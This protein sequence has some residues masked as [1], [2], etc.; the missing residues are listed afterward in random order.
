MQRVKRLFGSGLS[1][2]LSISGLMATTSMVEAA[3]S[4]IAIAIHGGA[5]TL[6][7]KSMTKKDRLA[8]QDALASAVRAGYAVLEGGGSSLDAVT[9][10]VQ[11]LEDSPRFN[12][13]VGAV[14]NWDGEHELDASIMRG[15]TM[16]AGAVAGVR[17]IKSPIALARLVM[18]RSPHVMLSGTGAEEFADAF[19][20]ERVSNDYFTTPNRKSAWRFW[21][22]QQ[23]A[24]VSRS[25]EERSGTV[26]AV[27]IDRSG[28]LAAATSTGGMTGKRWGRIGDSPVIGAGNW[29]DNRSCAVSATGH[30]EFFIRHN[31]AANICARVRLKGERIGKAANYV[32]NK[33]LVA[34]GGDGGVIAIGADGEVALPFNTP[35]MYRAVIDRDGKLRVG[36]HK[37]WL[38]IPSTP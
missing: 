2:I 18:E 38:R 34:A 16:E 12:A 19:E 25:I 5:G 7:P 8:L 31:V 28:L 14:M 32:I 9:V 29:A 3:E 37:R 13:G 6:N 17:T 22:D 30:G 23:G 11:R 1:L 26:G 36:F 20:L 15:D 33:E 35:G 4:P 27:A 10:A 24:K 21:R